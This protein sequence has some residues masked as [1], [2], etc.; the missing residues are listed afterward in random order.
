MEGCGCK[1][2]CTDLE[3][4]HTIAPNDRTLYYYPFSVLTE[5]SGILGYAFDVLVYLTET[6]SKISVRIYKYIIPKY[7]FL[8]F[9]HC[10]YHGTIICLLYSSVY[11][12]SFLG[13]L[14]KLQ[15]TTISFIM[16][17][18]PSVRSHGATWLPLEI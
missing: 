11:Q 8:P 17:F 3:Y 9:V 13:A 10:T 12:V 18:C 2:H 7:F 6:Y 15:K 4:S 5:N 1:T 14:K 16:S